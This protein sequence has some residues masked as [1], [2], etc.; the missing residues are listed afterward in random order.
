MNDNKTA[1][2]IGEAV[3]VAIRRLY[4]DALPPKAP[5]KG[6]VR[7][8]ELNQAHIEKLLG[9]TDGKRKLTGV[10][11]TPTTDLMGDIVVPTGA[12][13][14]LPLPLLWQHNHDLPIGWVREARVTSSGIAVTCELATGV[15]KADEAWQHIE[16]G[17]TLGLS[18]GFVPMASEAMA[19]GGRKFTKWRWTEL[20]V[21][22]IAAN[23]EGRV[24]ATKHRPAVQLIPLGAVKLLPLENKP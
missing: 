20:S 2:L 5:G 18:I 10:A 13:Y 23:P 15:G 6:Q 14:T 17:L 9:N 12:Q 11:T 16:A 8:L 7:R 24:T 22:T 1:T 4:A 21:C 19:N 3:A